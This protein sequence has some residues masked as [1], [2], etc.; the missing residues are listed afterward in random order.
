MPRPEPPITH[1]EPGHLSRKRGGSLSDSAAPES[2]PAEGERWELLGNLQAIVHPLL[3]LLSFLW[4]ILVFVDLTYGLSGFSLVLMYVVWAFFIT[5]YAVEL[6]IAPSRLAFLKANWLGLIALP[7]PALRMLALLRLFRVLQT[8][9]FVRA[10]GLARVLT[11]TNRSLTTLRILLARRRLGLVISSTVTVMFAGAGGIWA[12]EGASAGDGAGIRSFG[13]ALW[14]SAMM[15]TTMG[16]DVWP[17]TI[18]GRI[19]AWVMALY[20][21]GLFGYVTAFLATHFLGADGSSRPG[22]AERRDGDV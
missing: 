22:P 20:A 9:R 2:R 12:F 13:D 5:H 16:S 6:I 15:M 11:S 17:R 19:L 7:I 18:E 8:L 4:F 1:D 14:W 3:N 21:F 10:A